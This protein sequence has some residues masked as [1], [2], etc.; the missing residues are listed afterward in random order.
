VMTNFMAAS[1]HQVSGL[2][3]FLTESSMDHSSGKH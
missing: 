2:A 3:S 1:W